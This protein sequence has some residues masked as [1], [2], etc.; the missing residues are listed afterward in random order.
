MAFILVVLAVM[1][2]LLAGWF[3]DIPYSEF[4][5]W[6]GAFMLFFSFFA[7]YV[8]SLPAKLG[9]IFLAILLIAL[10]IHIVVGLAPILSF[11]AGMGTVTMILFVYLVL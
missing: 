9:V 7:I 6:L 3:F 5:L 2:A 1:V 4:T 11:I 10:Y 8:I